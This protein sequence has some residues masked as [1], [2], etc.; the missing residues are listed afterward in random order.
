MV[1]LRLGTE[2]GQ[3]PV[4]GADVGNQVCAF[5]GGQPTGLPVSVVVTDHHGDAAQFRLEHGMAGVARREP[6]DVARVKAAFSVLPDISVRPDECAGV[7]GQLSEGVDLGYPD[8]HVAPVLGT[9]GRKSVRPASGH[10]VHIGQEL[11]QVAVDVTGQ[12]RLREHD[13]LRA[14]RSG[15][16]GNSACTRDVAMELEELRVEF[17]R[18]HLEWCC[19]HLVPPRFG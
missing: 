11:R 16:L 12:G 3:D 18:S 19:V 10:G 6:K 4:A 9:Y 1:A 15:F 7:V 13:Q 5:D 8:G 17:D 2:L 14:V